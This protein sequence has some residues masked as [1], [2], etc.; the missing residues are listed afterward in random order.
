MKQ[1]IMLQKTGSFNL[2]C[3][4]ILFSISFFSCRYTKGD[5][6]KYLPGHYFYEIPS[7]E[8]QEL[9]INSDFRFKQI[10][11]TKGKRKVLYENEG[12][13]EVGGNEIVLKNW[14]ECYELADQKMLSAPFIASTSSGIYWRKPEG[15]E[16]VLIIIFDQTN[17][18]FRKKEEQ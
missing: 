14:L 2:I 18:I 7:G 1:I 6:Q 9:I 12:K 8:F 11:Y 5:A 10:I 17:Y 3:L 15:D 16:G 13:M 4:S